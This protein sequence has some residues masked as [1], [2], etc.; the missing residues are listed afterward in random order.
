MYQKTAKCATYLVALLSTLGANSRAQEME[1]LVVT[2]SRYS[3]RL[4]ESTASLSVV[5][6]KTIDRSTATG[7]A[8]L[9]RDV[10]GIQV[11]D[12]GQ[13]GL[14]RIRIR[15]ESSRRSAVLI[16]SQEIT[17]HH[18]V[19]TP[20]TVHPA[21][22]ERIEVLRGSGSVLYGSKALSGVTNV[23]TRK[24]GS[25]PLQSTLSA[26]YDGATEGHSLFASVF[27]NA[28]GLQYRL[29]YADSDH[30]ERHTP[31]GT[32]E[33]TAYDNRSLYAYMGKS[34]GNHTLELV[35]DSYESSADIFV[36]EEVKTTF[37]LTDFW[38]NTPQRDRQKLSFNYLWEPDNAYLEQLKI[39]AFRQDSERQFNTSATTVWYARDISTYD[40]LTTD[41]GLLQA[42][43]ALGSA[44]TLIS[45]IQ[46]LDDSVD[47][48]REV[49]TFSWTPPIA[50]SGVTH[51]NDRASIKTLA[52]FGQ[53]HWRI[54]DQFTMLAGLRQYFVTGKLHQTNREGLEAG[55][56]DDDNELIASL[57]F[58]WY[59]SDSSMLRANIAE[60][61]L[62]PSLMQLATGAYAGS[63]Y[64]NPNPDLEP[65][66]AVN[67]ELGWR[68][69]RGNWVVD[70]ALFY[71]ES[72]NY[73]DHIFCQVHDNCLS[74]RDKFYTNIG[75][76][77]A[78]GVELYLAHRFPKWGVQPYTSLTW[79][80][81][82][83]D[84]GDL[85]TWDTGIPALSG[86]IGLRLEDSLWAQYGFWSDAYLR[87]ESNSKEVEPGSSV[88]VEK[89]K[90]GWVTIN[91]AAGIALGDRDQYRLGIELFNL[92]NKSYTESSENLW[93]PKRSASVKFSVDL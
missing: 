40:E 61:Y 89:E 79:M 64:V 60:G 25:E 71:S 37:P 47:Q 9:L 35:W 32:I 23:I 17:D 10:P 70:T 7:L 91:L 27:G 65:E 31:E 63:R 86:R 29:A 77:T 48:Q 59:L 1:E 55:K 2:A 84:Y 92:G 67:Y 54:N 41:G 53:D 3:E 66:T 62:Y 26:S 74:T 21:M 46:Y 68:L 85:R 88:P 39:S 20:L 72:D 56:L 57:G 8:D 34:L 50:P 13:A 12:S 83:N 4:F 15:G 30:S 87:G 33:E 43:W 45:G 81:R 73:I 18:E 5:Q 52:V 80:Q 14:K 16:D 51:V 42:N 36:E 49:D 11:S 44:H 19:G 22:I 6:A 75:E 38:I 93:A 90:T 28:N 78:H 69:S 24:G 76:S 58:N 82:R